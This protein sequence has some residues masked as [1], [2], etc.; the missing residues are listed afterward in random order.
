MEMRKMNIPTPE[1]VL[2]DLLPILPGIHDALD[3]GA[4]KV[5]EYF[6]REKIKNE[7]GSLKI[8]PWVASNILRYWAKAH[9]QTMGH[10]VEDEQP[11]INDIPNNGLSLI[12]KRYHIKIRKSDNGGVP[13]PGYSRRMQAFFQQIPLQ[14]PS[15][16]ADRESN[17]PVNLILLWDVGREYTI[18]QL[19]M[20]CPESGE[21]TRS[22]VRLHW[23]LPV[24]HPIST[25]APQTIE[26]EVAEQSKDLPLT[27]KK[28]ADTGTEGA[29]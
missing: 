7:D 11:E 2:A 23:N 29:E 16:E 25:V 5:R 6:E 12:Y 8:D 1:E 21:V 22:S 28:P 13:G 14:F 19:A 24:P 9:L 4:Y 18:R 17:Q 3:V 26:I 10:D 27:T 15:Q 20:A